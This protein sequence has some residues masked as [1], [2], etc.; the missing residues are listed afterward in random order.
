[1]LNLVF[2]PTQVEEGFL[3]A[4]QH[5]LLHDKGLQS[6]KSNIL[7]TDHVAHVSYIDAF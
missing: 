1:M 2:L 6:H 5:C 4:N 3:Q 7:Y